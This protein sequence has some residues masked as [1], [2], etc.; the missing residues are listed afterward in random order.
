VFEYRIYF[1]SRVSI[2]K[3]SLRT[4][5]AEMHR[6]P[7]TGKT[8]TVVG[9]A[10][11]LLTPTAVE[12]AQN[13]GA[14]KPKPVIPKKILVCAPSNAAVD[15]LVIRFKKGL[16][17]KA[18]ETWIPGIV[19][20]GRSDAINAEVKDVTLE[21]KMEARMAPV[22]DASKGN[23]IGHDDLRKKNTEIVKERNAKQQELDNARA[24]K[25]EPPVG[26]LAE[27][28]R[29]NATLRDQRRQLDQQRDQKK[30]SGRNTEILRRQIQ[31]QIMNEAQIICATLSGS[32]H[33][34]LR[35]VNVDFETV[36]IDEAAQSVELSALIPLKFGCEKCIL[37]GDPQQLVRILLPWV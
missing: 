18:G 27:I 14:T 8:K 9:I 22:T 31:Q 17:T 23:A 30:E 7:G 15:E 5:E 24:Q 37:V 3:F 10:G 36:I 12:T 1:D 25:Q 21:E 32:G 28:D 35:N 26:L 33:E 6:P 2:E 19:R 29:L 13:L 11:A 4:G 34:M 20:L 16:R